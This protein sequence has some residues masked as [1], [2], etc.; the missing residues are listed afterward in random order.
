MIDVTDFFKGDNQPVSLGAFS[1]KRFNL[2][3]QIG[4][5][6]YIESIHTYPINTEV[7][8]VRT[9][10]STPSFTPAPFPSPFPST[11]FPAAW[12][13]GAVTMEMNNSFILLPKKLMPK[14]LFDPRVGFFADDYVVFN[15][16]QQRVDPQVFI[17]RWRLEPKDEDIEKWKRGEL[18]EPKKPIVYYIDPATPKKMASVPDTGY[19]RLA[20]GI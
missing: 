1:K 14:R 7:K 9:F 17:V 11:T 12:A 15:D 8:V 19:Q 6:S 3:S 16:N 5:R 13:T 4:D 2:G 18:V 20:G 10:T